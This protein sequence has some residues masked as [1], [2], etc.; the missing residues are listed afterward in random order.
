MVD[1]A[2]GDA[3]NLGA[4][5]G[6]NLLPLTD[7]AYRDHR[8]SVQLAC[9]LFEDRR[10]FP[11][12][13]WDDAL[14]WLDVPIPATLAALPEHAILDD[15][16]YAVLRQGEAMAMLRYPRFRF[17]PSQADALHVDLWLGGRNLLR[18]GGSFSY[19]TEAEWLNYF[20]GV[21]SH[22]TIEFDDQP[23]MP[24]LSRFL[25]GDWIA[26]D[27]SGPTGKGFAASYQSRAGW[28][29]ER[30][31]QLDT[32]LTVIDTVAGFARDARL[33]WRLAPGDWRIEDGVVTD[34]Q[35]RLAVS[36]DVPITAFELK[37]GWESRHYLERTPLPVLEVV[38]RQPGRIRSE[39]RW[40]L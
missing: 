7:G 32:H 1:P 36:A 26:T 2:S 9:A 13:P 12:G 39:Y 22:N 35:H 30:E 23:Q 34:G 3:P 37:S 33:R 8:P 21:R 24:R 15:G 27:T 25:L 6:A 31:I 4:N 40:T 17:R 19:N 20:G 11:A 14:E 16:G 5:D 10:A 28:R 29:H 18:D 38:I